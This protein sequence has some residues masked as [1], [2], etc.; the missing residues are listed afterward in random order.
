VLARAIH[1]PGARDRHRRWLEQLGLRPH[2]RAPV[3]DGAT[4]VAAITDEQ[5]TFRLLREV[6]RGGA[7]TIYQAED[8]ALGRRLA[9][10]RYH[11]TGDGAQVKHE[12]RTAALLRGPGVL[13]IYDANPAA[14]W[15]ASEWI[16]GGSMAERI[17]HGDVD[18]LWPMETWLL[19]LTRALARVHQAG[20]VHA[21]VKP[22]NVLLRAADDPVLADFGAARCT[23]EAHAAGTIG[24]MSP[25]RLAGGVADPRDDVY[26]L[27]RLIEDVIEACGHA[28]EEQP[29]L[30]A[31]LL[32]ADE[33]PADASAVLE[34]LTD[35]SPG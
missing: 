35:L 3:D 30:R 18:G 19:P 28:E 33:R 13:P 5:L 32:A 21:D 15:I 23:G 29:V 24:Y 26:A 31:C 20:W 1:T 4:V 12:A 34:W 11:H 2:R 6:A 9:F 14:G 22:G 7:G 17:S 16:A 8:I 10:K 27:G 25:E